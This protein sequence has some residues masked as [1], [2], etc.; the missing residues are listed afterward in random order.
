MN[1]AIL[2]K[3]KNRNSGRRDL[4]FPACFSGQQPGQRVDGLLEVSFPE[5][6]VDFFSGEL[7][8]GSGGLGRAN[9]VTTGDESPVVRVGRRNVTGLVDDAAGAGGSRGANEVGGHSES[10][11]CSQQTGEDGKDGG[12]E[13]DTMFAEN[14]RKFLHI[15]RV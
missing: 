4:C 15:R 2:P 1:R 7:G 14:S 9:A 11:V 8:F 5:H 12:K 10:A 3:K 6:F 13:A